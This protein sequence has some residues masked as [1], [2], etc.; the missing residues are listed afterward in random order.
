ME[1]GGLYKM[2]DEYF[3]VFQDAFLVD[4]KQERRPYYYMYADGEGIRWMIPLSSQ[5]ENYSKK[6]REISEKR[7]DHTCIF[8]HIIKIAGKQ[9]VALIGNMF[10]TTDGFIK[11]PFTID[12]QHYVVRNR[13][14]ISEINKRASKYLALVKHGKITPHVDI[15]KMRQTLLLNHRIPAPKTPVND[16]K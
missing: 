16:Q 10:P 1:S 14:T 15:M 11:S 4:N 3:A 12:G 6:I 5:V 7:K 13:R 9:R 2:K 8:Y